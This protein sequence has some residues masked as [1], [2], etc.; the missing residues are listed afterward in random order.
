MWGAMREEQLP[1]ISFPEIAFAG[2]SNVGKSSLIN[3]LLGRN[4]L[5]R[6][7]NTPGSTRQI[8]FFNL[9]NQLIL[10]DLPGYGYAKAPKGE[11]AGWNKLILSY[12]KARPSLARVCLLIDARH[13]IKPSDETIMQV[14]DNSALS[15][16]I[17]LTKADKTTKGEL[18]DIIN[19]IEKN[20]FAKHLALHPEIL[21]TS[22]RTSEG[23]EDLKVTIAKFAGLPSL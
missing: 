4:K 5:A 23:M 2:R 14:L 3:S 19:K 11:I 18:A 6:V 9:H 7:S 21:S 20:Y 1:D 17:V 8:N 10:V 15:Y 12:L 22:S 16:Q 13:G